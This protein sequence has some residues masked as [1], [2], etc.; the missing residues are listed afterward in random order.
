MT[1]IFTLFPKLSFINWSPG[2]YSVIFLFLLSHTHLHFL[3]IVYFVVKD[4]CGIDTKDQEWF[5]FNPQSLNQNGNRKNRTTME[6]FYKATGKDRAIKSR[7]SLIGMK[8]TLVYHRGRTPNGEGT[9]WVMHEYRTTQDEFDGTHPG[10]KAFV[11]CRLFN[12]EEK[13]NKGGSAKSKPALAPLSPAFEVQVESHQTSIQSCYSEISDEMMSDVA[14]NQAAEVT[15]TEVGF[16][17]D[18]SLNMFDVLSPADSP[19]SL[20]PITP[21]V[22]IPNISEDSTLINPPN[23]PD[24]FFHNTSCS[25]NNLAVDNETLKNMASFNDNGSCSG[26]DANAQV[27]QITSVTPA[28]SSPTIAEASLNEAESMLAPASVPQELGS[29]AD[30]YPP[31]FRFSPAKNSDGIISNTKTPI[32]YKNDGYNTSVDRN[33][34]EV[35][36]SDEVEACSNIFSISA[37]PLV[38]NMYSPFHSQ[39]Q[40]ELY[41]SCTYHPSTNDRHWG[42]CDQY[43]TNEPDPIISK[44]WDSIYKP[45]VYFCNAYLGQNNLAV[46]EETLKNMASFLDNGSCGGSVA[47]AQFEQEYQGLV[48]FEEIIKP[49]VSSSV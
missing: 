6:G 36:A 44:Y 14:K 22:L 49:K 40:A 33:Q 5:C 35:V 39:V 2:I 29:G 38:S 15:S 18:Q 28:V 23:N 32:E 1:K 20:S 9:K 48:R 41:S 47:N 25:Q 27:D 4:I 17:L 3:D 24:E 12:N 46:E 19:P 10:Q 31:S 42:V 8:K 43:G 16:N 45:D 26:S 34:V 21:D 13:S 30:N 11:L 7:G 37:E